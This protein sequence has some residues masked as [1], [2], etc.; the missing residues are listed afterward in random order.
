MLVRSVVGSIVRLVSILAFPFVEFS[1]LDSSASC[2]SCT[3]RIERGGSGAVDLSVGLQFWPFN[4][5]DVVVEVGE[6]LLTAAPDDVDD[7]CEESDT[8]LQ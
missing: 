8:L 4:L 1:H 5:V 3:K 2:P 7:R 6:S